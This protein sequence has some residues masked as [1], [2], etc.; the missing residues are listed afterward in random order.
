MQTY[1]NNQYVLGHVEAHI[2]GTTICGAVYTNSQCG[3]DT[4]KPAVRASAQWAKGHSQQ[5]FDSVAPPHGG[6]RT[7]RRRL[8]RNSRAGIYSSVTFPCRILGSTGAQNTAVAFWTLEKVQNTTVPNDGR[9]PVCWVTQ[10][11]SFIQLTLHITLLSLFPLSLSLSLSLFSLASTT[12]QPTCQNGVSVSY[13]KR[14][15]IW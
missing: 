14:F 11:E 7:I 12:L 13:L 2:T 3:I 8:K 4:Y 9:S 1:I 5:V 10:R 6:L 15:I